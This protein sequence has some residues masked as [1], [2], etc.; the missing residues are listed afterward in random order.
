[1]E[2]HNCAGCRYL[3]KLYYNV[4]LKEIGPHKLGEDAYVL[5]YCTAHTPNWL[6][7]LSGSCE[8]W[9]FILKGKASC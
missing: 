4:L 5:G 3:R 7:T 1:M 6:T 9:E 8:R 2:K